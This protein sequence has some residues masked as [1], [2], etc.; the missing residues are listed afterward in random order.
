MPQTAQRRMQVKVRKQKKFRALV[1]SDEVKIPASVLDDELKDIKRGWGS[2]DEALTYRLDLAVHA[3]RGTLNL[4]QTANELIREISYPKLNSK[5]PTSLRIHQFFKVDGA[6][7]EAWTIRNVWLSHSELST[8]IP[9]GDLG[10]F[11]QPSGWEDARKRFLLAMVIQAR[12]SNKPIARAAK[13]ALK[14][15]Q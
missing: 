5:L 2:D 13:P 1:T 15:T 11:P 10:R 8:V 12:N 4:I 7:G 6:T 3:S 9:Y 14:N